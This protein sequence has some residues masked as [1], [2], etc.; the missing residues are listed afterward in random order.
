MNEPNEKSSLCNETHTIPTA[1][2]LL[3]RGLV[4]AK[5][6]ALTEKYHEFESQT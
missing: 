1:I 5:K 3:K 4:C 2:L 6:L